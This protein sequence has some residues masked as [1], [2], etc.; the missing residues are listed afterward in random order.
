MIFFIV[1]VKSQ[2]N[3]IF[4]LIQKKRRAYLK[5]VD[6]QLNF[7]PELVSFDV[8]NLR[9]GD[10]V[11]GSEVNVFLN[12]N[13]ADIFYDIKENYERAFSLIFKDIS[14]RIFSRVAFRDIFP[15]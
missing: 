14:N 2:H 6:Y 13:W 5:V 12:A 10:T 4:T 3:L 9:I 7:N 11:V 1:K 8:K 15:E